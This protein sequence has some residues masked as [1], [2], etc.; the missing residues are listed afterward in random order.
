MVDAPRHERLRLFVERLKDAPPALSAEEATAQ[1]NEILNG[2]EDEMTEIPFDPDAAQQL[3]TDGR[4][5]GP[6]DS[7]ASDWKGRPDLI[8]FAHAKHDTIVGA[9]GAILIRIRRPPSIWL[10]KAGADGMEID[11]DEPNKGGEQV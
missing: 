2:V 5:Y 6:H 9:N 10:S 4:M 3:T 11:L 1:V 7:F 8:R